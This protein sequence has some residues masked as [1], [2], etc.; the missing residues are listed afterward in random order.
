[1][2]AR[3]LRKA[4]IKST[5]LETD[6][7]II[8][9][10]APSDA[11]DMF[12]YSSIDDVCEFL[13]WSAHINVDVTKGYIEFL[14]KRYIRG[15]YADWAVTLKDTGKM[16]GT[17]GYANI[18]SR[19][20]SCEIGYVLSPYYRGKGYMTESVLEVLKLTF[21][22][23]KLESAHLRIINEN[24]ASKRLAERIGFVLDRIGYSEMEIKGVRR[25][26]AHYVMTAEAYKQIKEKNEAV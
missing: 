21:D 17:C 23:L 13:L 15:L 18:N 14:Q 8:R 2:T 3:K 10:I 20:K 19:E 16:I 7:L 11:E 12:E 4:L 9:N 1:M 26:I 6:R 22:E 5:P 24:V 25:D